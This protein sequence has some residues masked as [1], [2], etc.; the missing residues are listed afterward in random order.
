MKKEPEKL[1]PDIHE[2]CPFCGAD[3][4][5]ES[6][7][8]GPKAKVLISCQNDR[9]FIGPGVTGN[10]FKT[11]LKRWNGGAGLGHRWVRC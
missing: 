1:S 3:A 10:N 5:V 7:H 2:P 4:F 6:W 8:G 11:A 9:C